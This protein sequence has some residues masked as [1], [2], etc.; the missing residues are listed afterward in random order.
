[1][2]A[3]G[4]TSQGYV[5]GELAIVPTACDASLALSRFRHEKKAPIAME[6]PIRRLSTLLSMTSLE[7][8][9]PS[10]VNAKA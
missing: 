4:A 3:R 1:M 2:P 6:P 10:P 7:W 8:L 9:K 5:G